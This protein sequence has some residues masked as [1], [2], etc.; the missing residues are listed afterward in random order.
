MTLTS[1]VD[2]ISSTSTLKLFLSLVS[3]WIQKQKRKEENK[4]RKRRKRV[5][6]TVGT[7]DVKTQREKKESG[8]I[9]RKWHKCHANF[10]KILKKPFAKKKL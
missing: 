6:N 8:S 1:L 9:G 5:E 7:E 10:L 3:G 2:Y 4:E